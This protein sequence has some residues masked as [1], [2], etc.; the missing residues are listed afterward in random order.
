MTTILSYIPFFSIRYHEMPQSTIHGMVL[1][2]TR[3]PQIPA[4]PISVQSLEGGFGERLPCRATI[5][6]WLLNPIILTSTFGICCTST[7]MIFSI[8]FPQLSG[9]DEAEGLVKNRLPTSNYR[10][11]S[12]FWDWKSFEDSKSSI[13]AVL[14]SIFLFSLPLNFD[15]VCKNHKIIRQPRYSF[16]F[17]ATYETCALIFPTDIICRDRFVPDINTCFLAFYFILICS[18]INF[19]FSNQDTSA[20]FRILL[21]KISA[22]YVC[23]PIL[24]ESGFYSEFRKSASSQVL[25]A[26]QGEPLDTRWLPVGKGWIFTS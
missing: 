18:R 13:W 11:R 6:W 17:P 22:S 20:I 23:T 14:L 1:R 21:H 24:P 10:H 12:E 2:L 9:V 8:K 4:I 26:L 5:P 7:K 19:P 3:Q 25:N 15:E 16:L